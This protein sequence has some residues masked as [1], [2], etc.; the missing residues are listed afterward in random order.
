MTWALIKYFPW[1]DKYKLDE[2]ETLVAENAVTIY[3]SYKIKKYKHMKEV[4][5]WIKEYCHLTSVTDRSD[6][7]LIA[8]WRAHNLLYWLGYERDRT[9]HCDL[10][11]E[12]WYRKI[13][14]FFLSLI[15]F[16]Q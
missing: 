11:N 12:Q 13:G 5:E 15:Y 4:V 1:C 10:N 16:G 6:F 7:S 14:Y 8:E 2:V 9:M 3:N